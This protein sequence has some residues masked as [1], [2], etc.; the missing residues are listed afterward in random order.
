VCKQAGRQAG[1]HKKTPSGV[2]QAVK[3]NTRYPDARPSQQK[4][5]VDSEVRLLKPGFASGTQTMAAG[6][7]GGG[8]ACGRR[9]AADACYYTARAYSLALLRPVAPPLPPNTDQLTLSSDEAHTHGGTPPGMLGMH[10]GPPCA[11]HAPSSNPSGSCI[12][13]GS[14]CRGSGYDYP[15]VVWHTLF[16]YQARSWLTAQFC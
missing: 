5:A 12:M 2:R 10:E 15:A 7:R 14:H 11:V 16:A 1:R 8:D 3:S 9:T 4:L 6:A 13:H